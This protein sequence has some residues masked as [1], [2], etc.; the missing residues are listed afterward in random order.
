MSAHPGGR[1]ILVVSLRPLACWEWG[2]ESRRFMDPTYR[3]VLPC[4]VSVGVIR[5]K[6][7]S[8]HLESEWKRS[9]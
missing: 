1:E 8:V 6:N 7:N 5:Y 2:F 9:D 4:V 3:E